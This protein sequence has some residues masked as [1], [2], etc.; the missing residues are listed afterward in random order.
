M[1]RS[2]CPFYRKLKTYIH[3]E[4]KG[5]NAHYLLVRRSCGSSEDGNEQS[6][7]Y[8]HSLLSFTKT[9]TN[10][11]LEIKVKHPSSIIAWSNDPASYAT[12]TTNN[13]QSVCALS[14]VL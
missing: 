9:K 13:R 14:P 4:S 6:R 8:L 1:P 7:I 10:V 5:K 12:I 2:F 3:E 11:Q